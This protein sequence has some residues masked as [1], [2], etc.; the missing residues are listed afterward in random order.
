MV[1]SFLQ[2]LHL[3]VTVYHTYHSNYA[4]WFTEWCLKVAFN[5]LIIEGSGGCLAKEQQP[6]N[7]ETP[8]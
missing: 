5:K 1:T 6:D 7:M 3:A 4:N 2:F 8:M